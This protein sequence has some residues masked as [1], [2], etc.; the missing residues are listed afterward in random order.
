MAGRNRIQ[1]DRE[2]LVKA[3]LFIVICSVT[4]FC[5]APLRL[6]AMEGCDIYFDSTQKWIVAA[7]TEPGT[8][9]G[10]YIVYLE[11]MDENGNPLL[12]GSVQGMTTNPFQIASDRPN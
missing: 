8:T 10:T 11:V 4:L 6:Y 7:Y 5:I 12:P 2:A 1:R 9:S 3:L